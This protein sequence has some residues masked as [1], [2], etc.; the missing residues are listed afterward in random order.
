[1]PDWIGRFQNRARHDCSKRGQHALTP[2]GGVFPRPFTHG[3][4]DKCRRQSVNEGTHE[5]GHK[6]YGGDLTLIDY[7]I[8]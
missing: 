8:N 7:I 4:G 2:P 1:M 3:G 6:P 5:G